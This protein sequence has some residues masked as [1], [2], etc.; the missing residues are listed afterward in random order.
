MI[1]LANSTAFF[2]E[3]AGV[4]KSHFTEGFMGALK[5]ETHRNA[6]E[7]SSNS[8]GRSVR[9]MGPGMPAPP[10]EAHVGDVAFVIL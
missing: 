2:S 3:S 5:L 4:L 9:T 7:A 8:R 10:P 6:T 1:E